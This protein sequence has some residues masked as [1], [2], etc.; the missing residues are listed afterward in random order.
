[1]GLMFDRKCK[2]DIFTQKGQSNSG[3]FDPLECRRR[4]LAFRHSFF[5]VN[6]LLLK[7]KI[8]ESSV[9]SNPTEI[10]KCVQ[11]ETVTSNM[12]ISVDL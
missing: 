12:N 11:N 1:M 2:G 8:E 6:A 10:H 7:D 5:N 4:R 3:M 9:V